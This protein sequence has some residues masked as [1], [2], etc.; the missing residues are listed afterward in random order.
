MDVRSCKCILILL[1]V[2]TIVTV[3]G[4]GRSQAEATGTDGDALGKEIKELRREV[5]DLRTELMTRNG[6]DEGVNLAAFSGA[7]DELQKM[8]ARM[9]GSSNAED[10]EP[11]IDLRR[12]LRLAEASHQA[13]RVKRLD[14]SELPILIRD[15]RRLK[16]L[17]KRVTQVVARR[18]LTEIKRQV[19]AA[20]GDDLVEQGYAVGDGAGR[21]T[22]ALWKL[23]SLQQTLRSMSDSAPDAGGEK[24]ESIPY[25]ERAAEL[26]QRVREYRLGCFSKFMMQ[27]VDTAEERF[28]SPNA[29]PQDEIEA[30]VTL[31]RIQPPPDALAHG[32]SRELTEQREAI[33]QSW[34]PKTKDE[35]TETLILQMLDKQLSKRQTVTINDF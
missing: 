13:I 22:R 18:T 19:L 20:P 34:T 32:V 21:L 25:M 23:N 28:E 8:I 6:S 31:A 35:A 2:S 12:Q 26:A 5:G 29:T 33:F 1:A 3:F 30:Y 27:E 9:E 4:C 24:G 11:A 14:S 7:L 16:R 10:A 17:R 15:G